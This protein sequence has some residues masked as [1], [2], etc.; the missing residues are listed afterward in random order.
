MNFSSTEAVQPLVCQLGRE[1][2]DTV[3]SK[4]ANSRTEYLFP[5]S[6]AAFGQWCVNLIF[7]TGKPPRTLPKSNNFPSLYPNT[8]NQELVAVQDG[9]R[10]V[11][12]S[13][14]PLL[15]ILLTVVSS[16]Q[17]RQGQQLC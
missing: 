4:L 16:I 17:A 1:S 13:S 14:P 3:T 6:D 5:F 10:C 9:Q 2:Q 15:D 11:L 8:S 7:T 12:M